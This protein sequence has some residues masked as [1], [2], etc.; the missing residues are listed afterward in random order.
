MCVP[1]EGR[2]R[3]GQ[4]VR[5]RTYKII[6]FV[7]FTVH[8]GRNGG[9]ELALFSMSQVRADYGVLE[10]TKLT[11]GVYTQESGGFWAM[12][13]KAPIPHR[14]NIAIFYREAEH[15][16][17]KELLLHVPNVISFQ[18]VTGRWRWHVVEYYISPRDASTIEDVDAAIRA[19]PYRAEF[20]VAGNL[21]ANLAEPEGTP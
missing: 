1:T 5:Q 9:R 6:S 13:T 4:G 12:V 2:T 20:L 14:G 15:F 10:E 19:Q 8:N 21:N 3:E 11:K 17:I 18:L 7:T 16:A